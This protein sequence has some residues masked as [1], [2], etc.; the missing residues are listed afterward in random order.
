MRRLERVDV[1]V[2]KVDLEEM[3]ATIAPPSP[4][5]E[6]DEIG[7]ETTVP[8]QPPSQVADFLRR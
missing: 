3:V 5:R 7:V 4:S 8:P 2:T 6:V 1:L